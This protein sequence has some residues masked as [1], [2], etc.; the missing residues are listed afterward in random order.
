MGLNLE[1]LDD[2]TRRFMLQEFDADDTTGRLYP[3]Q[4]FSGE[5]GK[6][7]S[8]LFR[9][10]IEHGN[11]ETLGV[12]LSAPGLFETH[13]LKNTP[14]GGTTRATVPRTA[15]VTFAEGEFNRFYIRGLCLRAA[16]GEDKVEVY[17]ARS[18]SRARAESEALIGRILD[19]AELL[20]DLRAHIGEAPTLLPYVNS[21]LSVRM[22]S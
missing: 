2:T 4:Y 19:A 14:S 18:S 13:Y 10:A 20:E 11:D 8:E 3:S 12:A 5:G 9:E 6:Q 17:R 21:G 22:P 1:N 15:P 16:D 7:F